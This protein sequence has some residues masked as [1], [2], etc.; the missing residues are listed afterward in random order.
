MFS[1][2]SHLPLS[3]SLSLT[4][5]LSLIL[6]LYDTHTLSLSLVI[7]LFLYLSLSSFNCLIS[8]T[9]YFPLFFLKQYISQYLTF[10]SLLSFPSL[11]LCLWREVYF[12]CFCLCTFKL[13]F[14]FPLFFSRT[15][16]CLFMCY[17]FRWS[18]RS[19]SCIK[20]E[21]AFHCFPMLPAVFMIP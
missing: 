8:L 15:L 19:R 2:F 9:H 21:F 1:I 18:F 20:G 6:S 16:S 13:H 4:L 12:F 11:C 5:S 7:F 3:L 10:I 17:C 14:H